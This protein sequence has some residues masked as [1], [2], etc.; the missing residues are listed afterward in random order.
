MFKTALVLTF[1]VALLASARTFPDPKVDEPRNMTAPET[2]V[3]AG[4]C[5]WGV[6]DV[7]DHV[8]GVTSA[9]SGYSGG[10]QKTARSELV[11]AGGTG[12]AEA[13]SITYDP[14]QITYGQ[15]LK[16]FFSVVHD[17]TEVDGQ[18]PD[19][20]PQYRSVIFY[21]NDSQKRIA[22]AYIR[23]LRVARVFR[24]K[25]ATQLVPLRGFYPAEP[26]HQHFSQRHPTSSYVINNDVPKVEALK[27]WFPQ[28][29]KD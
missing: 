20:G 5:F 29:Y 14:S 27:A 12:H 18:G 13:V 23:D 25:I 7:F 26:V 11:E 6:E 28:F 22:E 8:K 9:V 15:I 17:P 3:L 19:E 2:A 24:E 10:D 1:A 16:I 4:G 21:A